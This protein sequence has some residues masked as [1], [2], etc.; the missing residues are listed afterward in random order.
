MGSL[1]IWRISA[2]RI[3]SCVCGLTRSGNRFMTL[4]RELV[5]VDGDGAL[6]IGVDILAGALNEPGVEGS[7]VMYRS[8]SSIVMSS[9]SSSL[10]I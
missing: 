5:D 6:D 3:I 2:S 1:V 7:S 8:R 10:A 9:P 4:G